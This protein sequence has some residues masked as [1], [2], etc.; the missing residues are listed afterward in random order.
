MKLSLEK[1]G[2][3]WLPDVPRYKEVGLFTFK[4]VNAGEGKRRSTL[5]FA[6]LDIGR[7]LNAQWSSFEA[8]VKVSVTWH[9]G[10]KHVIFVRLQDFLSQLLTEDPATEIFILH[11]NKGK[12]VMW[13]CKSLSGG[14][15][16]RSR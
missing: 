1:P 2:S 3:I 7:L 11:V 13:H 12:V 8:R 4:K 9:R 16:M 10:A 6:T 5:R 15:K 14:K